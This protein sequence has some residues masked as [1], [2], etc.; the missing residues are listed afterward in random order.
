MREANLAHIL[1]AYEAFRAGDLDALRGKFSDGVVWHTPGLGGIEP[2]YKGV[3]GVMT[4]L[5]TLFELTDGTVRVEPEHMY[6]DDDRVVVLESV[7]ASRGDQH[8]EFHDVVVYEIRD[9]KTVEVTQY[10]VDVK[11]LEIFWA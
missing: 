5:T 9:G 3:D 2:T 8:I 10:E 6:A 11:A 7:S 1:S 4:Y